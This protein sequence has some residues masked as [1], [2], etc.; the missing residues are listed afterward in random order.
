MPLTMAAPGLAVDRGRSGTELSDMVR[1]RRFTLTLRWHFP[2][3]LHGST[4]GTRS[5]SEH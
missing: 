5:R 4:R 1:S 3:L 2:D